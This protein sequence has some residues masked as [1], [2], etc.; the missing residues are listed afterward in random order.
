[1]GNT[2][3]DS[4]RFFT[5]DAASR[6]VSGE[7]ARSIVLKKPFRGPLNF[8][9]RSSVKGDLVA[10]YGFGVVT[11]QGE[12]ELWRWIGPIE[13]DD[14]IA[15]AST[16]S[17]RRPHGTF[18]G[19]ALKS[20]YRSLQFLNEISPARQAA[21]AKLQGAAPTGARQLVGAND[22]TVVVYQPSR[23]S[24]GV[25]P[26]YLC[27]T[28]NLASER[29]TRL[30]EGIDG[31]RWFVVHNHT[32]VQ[33]KRQAYGMYPHS[34]DLSLAVVFG[35]SDEFYT[36]CS[37]RIESATDDEWSR[38]P[39]GFDFAEMGKH[40]LGV[41][42]QVAAPDFGLYLT[43]LPIPREPDKV[44]TAYYAQIAHGLCPIVLGTL[45]RVIGTPQASVAG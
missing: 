4:Q 20:R 11:P 27:N 18:G 29:R 40:I 6:F 12:Q 37:E 45:Q 33:D 30:K 3:R 10:Q 23:D 36:T 28:E 13:T 5:E 9:T 24:T 43:D 16:R 22:T 25:K 1:M 35:G 26:V 14:F 38:L 41:Y 34:L 2:E 15:F 31:R 39:A 21:W 42:A 8:V 17:A 7:W 32:S 44:R 19:D